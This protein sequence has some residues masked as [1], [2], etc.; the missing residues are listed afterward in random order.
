MITEYLD[1][2]YWFEIAA[3]ELDEKLGREATDKEIEDYI[4]ELEANA[5]DSA[6]ENYR[7]Q[8]D[9]NGDY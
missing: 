4:T 6:Y 5:I 7:D 8:L 1:R 3:E 2:D 9:R